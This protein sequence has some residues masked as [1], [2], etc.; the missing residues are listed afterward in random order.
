MLDTITGPRYLNYARTAAETLARGGI[1]THDANDGITN[2]IIDALAA[3]TDAPRPLG[4]KIR[5]RAQNKPEIGKGEPRHIPYTYA[6]LLHRHVK[7]E[8]Q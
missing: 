1:L 5:S 7:Q 8:V 2:R 4:N 6:G 3:R